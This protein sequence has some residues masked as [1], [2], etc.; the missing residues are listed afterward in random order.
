MVPGDPGEAIAARREHRLRDEVAAGDEV[1]RAGAVPL[2]PHDRPIAPAALADAEEHSRT[3]AQT[4]V[5]DVGLRREGARLVTGLDHPD[6]LIAAL[7]EEQT[8]LV[9]GRP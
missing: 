4:A 5:A 9:I 7:D 8:A 6:L 1:A 2:D 3:D